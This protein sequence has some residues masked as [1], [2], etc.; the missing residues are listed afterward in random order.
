MSQH[1]NN[2]LKFV[3]KYPDTQAEKSQED[4]VVWWPA[5]CSTSFDVLMDHIPYPSI[6][7]Y[8]VQH[9]NKFLSPTENKCITWVIMFNG[10]ASNI[11][12]LPLDQVFYG[13]KN[14][15]V[16]DQVK[17]FLEGFCIME[18]NFKDEEDWRQAKAEALHYEASIMSSSMYDD[19]GR[20]VDCPG[21]ITMDCDFGFCYIATVDQT[22]SPL[23]ALLKT[24]D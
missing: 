21:K 7:D 14:D 4:G 24:Q 11:D 15:N 17:D 6:K 18:K 10:G 22:N 8:C 1:I 2:M 16:K 9:R 13:I 20:I 19:D 3:R 23:N 12:Q 5:L